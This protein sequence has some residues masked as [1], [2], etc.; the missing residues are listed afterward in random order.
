MKDRIAKSIFCMTWSRGVLQI[1]S[2]ALTLI[3]ARWLN[4][5]DYGL[6]ALDYELRIDLRA[7]PGCRGCT[8]PRPQG[9]RTQLVSLSGTGDRVRHLR[10]R[11]RTRDRRLVQ[12][13]ALTD[14]LAQEPLE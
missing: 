8:V 13:S 9:L 10:F 2:F 6:M 3:V 5:S 12:V 4:P 7:R 11:M 14:V 1:T